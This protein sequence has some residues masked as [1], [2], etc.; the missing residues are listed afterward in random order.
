MGFGASQS[1]FKQLFLTQITLKVLSNP[2]SGNWF[3]GLGIALDDFS[4]SHIMPSRPSST[5]AVFKMPLIGQMLVLLSFTL[6]VF[7]SPAVLRLLPT[8]QSEVTRS[9]A[10][11]K[12]KKD[13]NLYSQN[14]LSEQ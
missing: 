1:F 10:R 8:V 11:S 5:V 4:I 2:T 6:G 14:S 12:S 3:N 7:L 13:K 9:K